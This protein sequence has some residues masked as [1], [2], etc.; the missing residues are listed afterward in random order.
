MENEKAAQFFDT[1]LKAIGAGIMIGIG[2]TVFLASENKVVGALMFTVGLFSICSFGLNLFTGKI[3]Y[4]V[5]NKNHPDCLTIWVG[6]FIGCILTGALVRIARPELHETALKMVNAKLEKS[7]I[8]VLILSFFCGILMYAAVENFRR[9]KDTISGIFG[10]VMCVAVFILSGFEH[11]IA[12]MCYCVFAV[13]SA[14]Y[15]GRS[16]LFLL[17]VTLG[18]SIGALALRAITEGV[19]KNK[20]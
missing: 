14:S 17:I 11:S 20:N 4:I 9:H 10:V 7:F 2:A 6:N 8:S 1:L 5:S 15:A 3:G 19:I 12:D 18:N 16:I 13:D